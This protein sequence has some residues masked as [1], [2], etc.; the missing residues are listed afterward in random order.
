M[1]KILSIVVI[2]VLI[3]NLCACDLTVDPSAAIGNMQPGSPQSGEA[4]NGEPKEMQW[5]EM[6]VHVSFGPEFDLVIN[7][8]Y[9]IL[10]ATLCNEAAEKLLSDIKLENRYYLL[11]MKEVLQA[12]NEQ[13]L[14]KNDTRMTLKA[15]SHDASVW[16]VRTKELLS[17]PVEYFQEASG[18]V[19]S[20]SVQLPA[21][22]PKP[23]DLS[24][25][26]KITIT[27]EDSK[28]EFY[29]DPQGE[30]VWY[31]E[32]YNDGMIVEHLYRA[33]GDFYGVITQYSDGSYEHTMDTVSSQV[34]VREAPEGT[35]N[36]GYA[37]GK[38]TSRTVRMDG[39]SIQVPTASYNYDADGSYYET[40]YDENGR[41]SLSIRSFPDGRKETST[42]HSN[43]VIAM[44]EATAAEGRTMDVPFLNMYEEKTYPAEYH[45]VTYDENGNER[46]VLVKNGDAYAELSI[47]ENN[48]SHYRIIDGDRNWEF[49]YTW[50]GT[51]ASSRAI[52][53]GVTYED[54]GTI[55]DYATNAF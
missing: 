51:K 27:R 19:F 42:Y 46:Q 53:D 32:A 8:C 23:L 44:Y 24:I 40:I 38:T 1:K 50:D 41:P 18:I 37:C 17:R 54:E 16:T 48:T 20:C 30:Y 39:Q 15:E 11:A 3:L 25:Y 28:A 21:A 36:P 35:M 45:K 49:F 5:R 7:E 52:I 22:A 31:T 12:A 13:N 47:E 33:P 34:W 43:G 14:L 10:S 6:T 9:G 4:T 29:Q 55:R 2:F 26:K